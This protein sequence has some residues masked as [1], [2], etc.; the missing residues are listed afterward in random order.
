MASY[1][2]SAIATA[3]IATE[4]ISN[5]IKHASRP[6][7]SLEIRVGFHTHG[8]GG[9][10]LTVSDNGPGMSTHGSSGAANG[11]GLTLISALCEQI[12]AELQVEENGGV[13]TRVLVPSKN[14][15]TH[16]YS[17]SG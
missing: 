10:V 15:L 5:A 9:A 17:P 8:P 13:E 11:V 12:E 3:L 4:L 14:L 7:E 16:A 6:G 2:I 1:I